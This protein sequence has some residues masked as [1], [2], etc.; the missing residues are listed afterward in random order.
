MEVFIV[1]DFEQRKVAF[2][3]NLNGKTRVYM[4]DLARM[5]VIESSGLSKRSETHLLESYVQ[6]YSSHPTELFS[7][8][9]Y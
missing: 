5:E 3:E 7:I 4:P 6:F 9:I 2:L 8:V 1:Q